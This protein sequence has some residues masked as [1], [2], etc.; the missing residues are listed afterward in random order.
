MQRPDGIA[1]FTATALLILTAMPCL[2]ASNPDISIRA[3]ADRT[4]VRIGDS[5]TY[6]VA[7]EYDST[8]ALAAASP[9]AI[10]TDFEIRSRRSDQRLLAGGRRSV[11]EEM[12]LTCW[13]SGDY[14]ISTRPYVLASA[15]GHR[16]TL[17]TAAIPIEVVST[18]PDDAR[19]IQDIK[20]PAVIPKKIPVWWSVG[21][22]AAL[23][24]A[25]VVLI[26]WIGRR[27]RRPVVIEV[28]PPRPAHEVAFEAL[29]ELRRQNLPGSGQTKAYYIALSETVRRYLGARFAVPAMDRT[30]AEL[31]PLLRQVECG[32]ESVGEIRRILD[33]S[34]NAKFARWEGTLGDAG[35]HM[36]G[37]YSVVDGTKVTSGERAAAAEA[38]AGG[39]D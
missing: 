9:E 23:I 6:S 26:W 19:D 32:R 5:I 1:L 34:D 11:T 31:L 29:E 16:D 27:R 37:A 21:A 28:R 2:A 18:L 38:T 20:G 36:D 33:V 30:T 15:D 35:K 8:L 7:V 12:V 25:V 17:T 24:L 3:S 39:Q 14:E 4:I 10:L 13:A 22:S